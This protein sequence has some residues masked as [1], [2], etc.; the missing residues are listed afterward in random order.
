MLSGDEV[1][2]LLDC[3]NFDD[4]K[5]EEEHK[6]SDFLVQGPNLVR[7]RSQ[8]EQLELESVKELLNALEIDSNLM[9][10]GNRIL[11]DFEGS[12]TSRLYDNFSGLQSEI[13]RI[14]VQ[15]KD[16]AKKV[17][18]LIQEAL[19]ERNSRNRLAIA[20]LIAELDAL[21]SIFSEE[22]WHVQSIAFPFC[23]KFELKQESIPFNLTLIFKIREG[24]P[25]FQDALISCFIP[26]PYNARVGLENVSLLEKDLNNQSRKCIGQPSI[27]ELIDFARSWLEKN[28]TLF[29]QASKLHNGASRFRF[30]KIISEGVNHSIDRG[31]I[32]DIILKLVNEL[33]RLIYERFQRSI[34]RAWARR[35][36][37]HSNWIMK[38]AYFIAT[39]N[40]E[41]LSAHYIASSSSET[42]DDMISCRFIPGQYYKC[43]ACFE[44]FDANLGFQP[45]SC[46][47]FLCIEC[48]KM[49][50][51]S[52]I[53]DG[54]FEIFCP[55]R[56]D[57][58]KS[59]KTLLDDDFI[60]AIVSSDIFSKFHTW[61]QNSF[62]QAC[63]SSLKWCVNSDCSFLNMLSLDSEALRVFEKE[64]SIIVSC[65]CRA[66]YCPFCMLSGGHWPFSCSQN[67]LAEQKRNS[68]SNFSKLKDEYY[69]VSFQLESTRAAK[70]AELLEKYTEEKV[71]IENFKTVITV[72][73]NGRKCPKCSTFWEK[74]GGCLH[75]T[76]GNCLFEWC[77]DCLR[78]WQSHT[79]Y[80]QCSYKKSEFDQ[81][82]AEIKNSSLNIAAQS[83]SEKINKFSSYLYNVEK[84]YQVMHE[85]SNFLHAKSSFVQIKGSILTLKMFYT[86]AEFQI[87]MHSLMSSILIFID[88]ISS[89]FSANDEIIGNQFSGF[90]LT[91]SHLAAITSQLDQVLK[92]VYPQFKCIPDH[93]S[94]IKHVYNSKSVEGLIKQAR[95][96]ILRA[97][98]FRNEFAFT[99]NNNNNK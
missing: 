36:L 71:T 88:I 63:F 56:L 72:E 42:Y 31:E 8:E 17:G 21:Q 3:W 81:A 54:K 46:G 89:E 38:E 53:D 51:K 48:W 25:L 50:L 70:Q 39:S 12:D 80:F 82:E 76:C 62:I 4:Q 41:L 37:R 64:G 58:G 33:I 69:E 91:Y 99:L 86:L 47:H 19:A 93:N 34:S 45:Q 44:D 78:E 61:T 90:M 23:L 26:S 74:N 52:K 10:L 79:N 59:C 94:Q 95:Y 5:E 83:L 43:I 40:L 7:S 27:Y 13:R 6:N 9:N 97:V 96:Q 15:K 18:D 57:D 22:M 35:C 20:E 98:K 66:S 49:L 77:W 29:S 65:I 2:D 84:H 68:I 75:M 24:Y 32:E 28:C 87:C 16:S 60:L 67:M 73:V 92:L 30:E 11:E 55:G 85:L 1:D 14:L